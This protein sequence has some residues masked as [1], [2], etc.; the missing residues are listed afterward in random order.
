GA[1]LYGPQ[2]GDE[3]VQLA[4]VV[5]QRRRREQQDEVALDLLDELVGCAAV[6]LDLVR[7][8]HDHEIPV[9]PQDLLGVAARARPVVRHDRPG[10]GNAVPVFRI[11]RRLE[12]LEELP[13]QLA[14]PLAHERGRRED[15]HAAGEPA[16]RQLLVDDARLDRFAETDFV[17][18]DGA[19]AHLP[20]HPLGDVD[21]VG[22]LL[23]R[24]GVE[25]DR[26]VGAGHKGGPR[27]LAPQVVPGALGR[28]APEL[29][30]EHRERALVYG[31]DVCGWCGW[32]LERGW[33]EW[34]L[35]H[36]RAARG[37]GVAIFNRSG[38]FTSRQTRYLYQRSTPPFGT[39][40]RGVS[41][42]AQTAGGTSRSATGPG[43]DATGRSR[44]LPGR[45]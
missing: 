44:R 8:V 7:L 36:G 18:E 23:D 41:R 34:R 29:L 21:L 20:Q 32:R 35:R 27:R 15:Q 30:G 14:L 6:A 2:Q 22:Q 40:W 5:L 9:V 39:S 13:L 43:G 24:V 17:G 19:A 42:S 37:R 31:P 33:G 11:G 38:A 28:R 26:P 1:V 25:G 4:Q 16:N 3:V 45:R 10:A 12:P